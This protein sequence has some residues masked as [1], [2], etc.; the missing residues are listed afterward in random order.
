MKCLSY[1]R[2][3]KKR[4]KRAKVENRKAEPSK[5]ICTDREF[6]SEGKNHLKTR[7]KLSAT[8]MHRDRVVGGVMGK[9]RNHQPKRKGPIGVEMKRK[10]RS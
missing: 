5:P 4:K 8:T 9:R 7:E 3:L 2:Q 1:T 10:A 6:Y